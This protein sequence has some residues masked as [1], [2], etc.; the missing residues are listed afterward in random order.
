MLN[1]LIFKNSSADLIND[2][3]HFILD[4]FGVIH[5]GTSTYPGVIEAL[6]KLREMNKKIY[7]L[8]NAPRRAKK[9]KS[10]L[11]NFGI[12]SDFYDFVVTSGETAFL[13]LKKNQENNFNKFGPNYYFIGQQR[14]R[15]VIEESNYKEVVQIKEA[16][17]LLVAGYNNDFSVEDEQIEVL[18]ECKKYNLPLICINPDFVVTKRSGQEIL[19]AGLIA[20]QYQEMG[21]EVIYFG[22]PY[23]AVYEAIFSVANENDN[24]KFLAIG[25]G[26]ETDIK[27][28]N[29]FKIDSAL[30]CG[31][32]LSNILNIKYGKLPNEADIM[33]ICLENKIYPKFILAQL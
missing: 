3:D 15:D 13:S 33:N 29:Q 22:K 9:V 4:I 10:V 1:Q 6:K 14:D 8:S 26:I 21:G 23:S 32:I 17:F 20:K 25:D 19:C 12:T 31:G 27:G 28:A 11:E 30:I 24:R 18:K 5:D 7:F 2:Y 16:N